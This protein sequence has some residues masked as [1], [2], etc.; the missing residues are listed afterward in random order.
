MKG[1]TTGTMTDTNGIFSFSPLNNPDV[2]TLVASC[3]AFMQDEVIIDKKNYA[4]T[5]IIKLEPVRSAL[6]G[7]L[8]VCRKPSTKKEVKQVSLMPDKTDDKHTIAFNIFP[9][10]VPSGSNLNI[11][12]I[13]TEEGYYSFLLQNQSGQSVHQQEIW[14]DAEARLL[15]IDIPP[16]AAGSYFLSL[17]TKKSGKRFTEKIIIQ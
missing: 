7:E 11:E 13:Q 15:N 3:V 16:V 5:I 12:L 6:L 4:D 14:I 2:I 17:I 9:N 1:T 8:V 10:P